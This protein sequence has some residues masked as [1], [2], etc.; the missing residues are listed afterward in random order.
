[1]TKEEYVLHLNKLIEC[2]GQQQFPKPRIALI[3]DEV[4]DMSVAWWAAF[5]KR[6]IL[7]YNPRI[8]IAEAIR[9]ERNHENDVQRAKRHIAENDEALTRVTEN[10]FAEAMRKLGAKSPTEAF[11]KLRKKEGA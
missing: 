3:Y 8:N 5:C 6:M 2:F 1:M 4:Q 10:G 7:E 11:L 9:S